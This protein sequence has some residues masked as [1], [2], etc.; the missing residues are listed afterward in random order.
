MDPRVDLCGWTILYYI[1]VKGRVAISRPML[2][3]TNLIDRHEMFSDM[4]NYSLVVFQYF[5]RLFG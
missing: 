3:F 4:K 5:R 1:P 2:Y